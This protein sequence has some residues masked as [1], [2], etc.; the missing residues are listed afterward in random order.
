MDFL[1]RT[2][3]EI[4]LDCIAHNARALQ[5]QL[6]AGS[7]LMAVVKANAYGHGDIPVAQTL[8]Q[9]GA[10]WLGV[11]NLEEALRL[12]GAE[13]KLPILIFGPTPVEYVFLLAGHGLTQ[14]IH[15]YSYGQAL[16]QAAAAAGQRIDCHWKLDTGMHRLGFDIRSPQT[17]P[18]LLELATSPWLQATGI[19][20]HF[21]SA[22]EVGSDAV[23][24]SQT[25]F[26]GFIKICEAL[27]QQGVS[28]GLR[29][30]CNSAAA[31]RYPEM[32]LDMVRAGIAI[33]GLEPCEQREG[34][35]V[36]QPALALY[37]TVTMLQDILPGDQLSYGR[38]YTAPNPRRVATVAIGY[39]DGYSRTLSG[40]GC[41]LVH[42]R[43]APVLGRVCM[44]QL[45][46]DV[47]D[48]PGV[49]EGDVVTVVDSKGT[50][51]CSLAEMARQT[52][53]IH[54]ECA[55]RV[56][57]RVPRVYLQGGRQTQVVDYLMP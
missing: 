41:M 36:L 13:L 31:L 30:C 28:P 22:D 40:K 9:A 19:Y 57:Q 23:A 38:T 42:G 34:Q 15:S 52:G 7:S 51:G 26:T 24:Y 2:W 6:A 29:H 8:A 55:C 33:Y 27:Q 56:G 20:T 3:A 49:Q 54:Y 37:T 39:A 16:M 4:D 46:L 44:D 12:R 17:L 1:R 50:H 53:T 18:Q 25:Q 11:S 14:T 5:G 35:P 45:L 10:A 43:P 21:A 48:I 47:T 32:H